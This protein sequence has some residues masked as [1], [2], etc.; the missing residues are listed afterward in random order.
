MF[1][2]LAEYCGED[3]GERAATTLLETLNEFTKSIEGALLKYD[4]EQERKAKKEAQKKKESTDNE[5]NDTSKQQSLKTKKK[6]NHFDETKIRPSN[7]LK[8][9]HV[10]YDASKKSTERNNNFC[11][12][13]SIKDSSVQSMIK[14]QAND[15]LQACDPRTALLQSISKTKSDDE[16][17]NST[18]VI[19]H[20]N[21]IAIDPR[22]AL[23]Q[24]ISQRNEENTNKRRQAFNRQ[25][26]NRPTGNKLE[27]VEE[28]G[29]D[30]RKAMLQSMIQSRTDTDDASDI[31]NPFPINSS[32]QLLHDILKRKITEVDQSAGTT[33]NNKN[34]ICMADEENEGSS[35]DD[36]NVCRSSRSLSCGIVPDWDV[37]ISTFDPSTK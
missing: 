37:A 14:K 33:T 13:E 2:E 5:A 20:N 9:S 34:T 36:R 15:T 4:R 23:L 24:S 26:I 3:G 19:R 7:A 6:Q 31:E 1:Q 17:T 12:E 30:P 18:N 25:K 21:S 11:A 22:A 32:N 29:V 16:T 28:E 10:N 35:G 8:Q 27:A